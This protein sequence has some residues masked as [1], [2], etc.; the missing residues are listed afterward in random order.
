MQQE[1]L[2][3]NLCVDSRVLVLLRISAR[4]R[5]TAWKQ[6]VVYFKG[7]TVSLFFF[8]QHPNEDARDIP[9]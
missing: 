4:E 7:T 6:Y 3:S 1:I 2:K 5:V 8:F 9:G